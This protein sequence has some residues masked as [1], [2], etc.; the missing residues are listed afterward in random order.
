MSLTCQ[1]VAFLLTEYQ[2]NAIPWDERLWIK[3]GT[4]RVGSMS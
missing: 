1:D 4:A 2:E 3:M